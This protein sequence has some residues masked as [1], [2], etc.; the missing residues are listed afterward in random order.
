MKPLFISFSLLLLSLSLGAQI[1]I[2]KNI[3]AGSASSSPYPF[4]TLASGNLL[5]LADDGTT[6]YELWTTDG[7]LANT[8]LL[9]DMNPGASGS[10]STYAN[11]SLNGK[12]YFQAND[13]THGTEPWVTDGTVGGTMMLSDINPGISSSMSGGTYDN[14]AIF[15]GKVYFAANDG[16]NGAE[17]WVTDGTSTGTQIVKNINTTGSLGSDPK[18]LQVA[19]GKLFFVANDGPHGSEWW[20]SDGTTTGTVLLTDLAAGLSDGVTA[21]YGALISY[22]S[23]AYFAGIASGTLGMELYSTD[24]TNVSL[25]KD[26][27]TGAP[28]STPQDFMVAGGKLFFSAVDAATGKELYMTDGTGTGTVLV[29]NIEAAAGNSSPFLLGE[30]NGKLLFTATTTAL[31]RELWTSDGTTIGTTNLLDIN[32]GAGNG[33]LPIVSESYGKPG[34]NL[35]TNE[36]ISN[37]KYYFAGDDG[38]NGKELWVTDGTVSGTMMV[39]GQIGINPSNTVSSGLDWILVANNT[40]WLRANDGNTGME[41]F[42]YQISNIGVQEV[43]CNN[44]LAVYPNPNNGN[45]ILKLQHALVTDGTISVCDITG[46]VVHSSDVSANTSVAKV[47]L[48]DVPKGMYFVKLSAGSDIHIAK[49]VVE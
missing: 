38:T 49:L 19:L 32:T 17:L 27:N 5:F 33:L 37:G 39:P 6:G 2:V 12:I 1:S 35:I 45:F 40:A 8:S 9:V 41:L 47:L 15:N 36:L 10:F 23:M 14:F 24:G 46:R 44:A 42:K 13:G 26:I 30:I 16:T 31:G 3:K 4:T 7:T 21:P 48:A 11:V 20:V 29:K 22:N 25:V 18:C 43:K 28:S 34:F